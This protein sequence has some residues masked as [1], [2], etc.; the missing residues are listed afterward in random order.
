MKTYSVKAKEIAP[1]WHVVDAADQPLGRIASRVASLLRGKH[2][3]HFVPHMD[4][5]DFVVVVNAERVRITGNNKMRQ[6]T[7]Y[8]H[9]M[10]PGGLKR[11]SLERMMATHPT[12]VIE[13]AVRGMLPHNRLGARLYR[14]L[15]VYVGPDHPH[16]AQ[17]KAALRQP[18]EAVTA[19]PPRAKA[20]KKAAPKSRAAKPQEKD[21][22]KAKMKAK[23]KAKAQPKKQETSEE[24]T[25]A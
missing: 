9:S 25:S 6:K 16:E 1:Q 19:A 21:K 12:R 23:P 3:P 24:D 10:Y 8:R 7:Y 13:H 4:L 17:F 5:R 20:R 18:K 15:K 22:P 14:H 2:R 11:T